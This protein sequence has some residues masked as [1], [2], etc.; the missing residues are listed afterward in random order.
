MHPRF[1]NSESVFIV[2]DTHLFCL[3]ALPPGYN[4]PE[5]QN[6][7]LKSTGHSQKR[8]AAASSY[9]TRVLEALTK[10]FLPT[11]FTFYCVN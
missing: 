10:T 2:R 6:Y 9:H 7:G 4:F 11:L 5:R 3:L 8:E 1:V